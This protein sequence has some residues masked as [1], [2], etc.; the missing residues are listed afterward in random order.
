MY[1]LLSVIG[2]FFV[3]MILHIYF[4][5]TNEKYVKYFGKVVQTDYQDDWN[6]YL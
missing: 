3:C 6:F 5:C 2:I 4:L 1:L